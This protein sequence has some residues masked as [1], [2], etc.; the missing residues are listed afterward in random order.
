MGAS[1]SM[2]RRFGVGI[3][4]VT[5]AM[6]LT[7]LLITRIF[8][9]VLWYHL[10]FFV[11]SLAFLGTSAGAVAAALFPRLTG[12]RAQER[13]AWYALGLSAA[14]SVGLWCFLQIRFAPEALRFG[15]M[16]RLAATA[17][18]IGSPFAFGGITI[19]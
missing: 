5:G 17:L 4:C 8:S 15:T 2:S 9:V 10:A 11:V 1:V 14:I 19:A 12:P 7:Q 13:V 3:A 6:L 18:L 16:A